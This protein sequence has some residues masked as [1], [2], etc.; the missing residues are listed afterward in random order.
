MSD[1]KGEDWFV[2]EGVICHFQWAEG[3]ENLLEQINQRSKG[4]NAAAGAAVALDMSC[5][6]NKCNARKFSVLIK[7]ENGGHRK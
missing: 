1:Y 5:M 6:L 4:K 2:L 7:I 3:H